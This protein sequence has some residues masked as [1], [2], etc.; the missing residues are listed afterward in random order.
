MHCQCKVNTVL[1]CTVQ[2]DGATAV[3][4][5]APICTAPVWDVGG[6]TDSVSATGDCNGTTNVSSSS[7]AK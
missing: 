3:P 1:L 7:S 6:Y 5:F 4:V 2:N